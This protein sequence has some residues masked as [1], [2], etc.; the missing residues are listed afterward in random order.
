MSKSMMTII[1]DVIFLEE[2][3]WAMALNFKLR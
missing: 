1:Q 2:P 3:T